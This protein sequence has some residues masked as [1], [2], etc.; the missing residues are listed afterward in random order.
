MTKATY[1]IS[2]GCFYEPDTQAKDFIVEI[3]NGNKKI[4][5]YLPKNLEVYVHKDDQVIDGEI[6]T[7]EKFKELIEW[8][9]KDE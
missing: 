3:F 5:V 8:I 7:V 1:F 6:D 2:D 9:L 4:S